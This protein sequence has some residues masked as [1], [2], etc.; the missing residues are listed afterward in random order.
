MAK[1]HG[2]LFRAKR[3]R[4]GGAIITEARGTTN[5][6]AVAVYGRAASG[7]WIAPCRRASSQLGRTWRSSTLGRLSFPPPSWMETSGLFPSHSP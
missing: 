5:Q 4:E 2:G 1:T 6:D 3:G 7:C